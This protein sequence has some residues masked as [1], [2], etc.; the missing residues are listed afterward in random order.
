M[1]QLH[2]GQIMSEKLE[3]RSLNLKLDFGDDE[4]ARS[5]YPAASMLGTSPQMRELTLEISRAAPLKSQRTDQ[6]RIRD[7]QDYRGH[8]DSRAERS[9]RETIR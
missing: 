5:A 9:K 7:R 4:S 3:A 1:A 2:E 6:R 8:H